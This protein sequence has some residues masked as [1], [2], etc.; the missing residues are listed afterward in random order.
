M[1]SHNNTYFASKTSSSASY[2]S[3]ERIG[4]NSRHGVAKNN[5]YIIKINML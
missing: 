5:N 3:Q 4:K 2:S 1:V